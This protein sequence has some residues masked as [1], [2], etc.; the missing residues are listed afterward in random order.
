MNLR[1]NLR[2][3]RI[4]DLI[5]SISG[6]EFNEKELIVIIMAKYFISRRIAKEYLDVAKVS[7]EMMK[8]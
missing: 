1:E 3:T 2:K 4:Q 5:N 7:L 8:K 6:K